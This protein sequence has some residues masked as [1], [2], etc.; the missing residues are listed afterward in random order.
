[1]EKIN[2]MKNTIEKEIDIKKQEDKK[3]KIKIKK[4]KKSSNLFIYILIFFIILFSI[5]IIFILKNKDNISKLLDKDKIS[6]ENIEKEIKTKEEITKQ[7]LE[8]KKK[9]EEFKKA[10][11]K[12]ELLYS[13]NFELYFVYNELILKGNKDFNI[14]NFKNEI[15]KYGADII[16]EDNIDKIYKIKFNRVLNEKLLMDY[17]AI[18]KKYYG[19]EDVVF[20]LYKKDEVEN[21]N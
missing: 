17:V 8:K 4:Q 6:E 9:E 10:P 1:M 7:K 19:C 20:N 15:K 11:K 14:D 2:N 21:L 12:E 5:L 18:F 13:E 16:F 3:N